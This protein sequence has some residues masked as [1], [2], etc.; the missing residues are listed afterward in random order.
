MQVDNELCGNIRS[1][2]V[3][4]PALY[5]FIVF[6]LLFSS[7][8]T[9]KDSV[10]FLADGIDGESVGNQ[11]THHFTAGYQVDQRDVANAKKVTLQKAKS[12]AK[13]VL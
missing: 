9:G 8:A 12:L 4:Q 6:Q 13:A 3:A 7:V 2:T 10:K 5:F 11:F 1:L